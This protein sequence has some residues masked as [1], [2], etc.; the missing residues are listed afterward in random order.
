MPSFAF[1]MRRPLD[2]SL[3]SR[4]LAALRRLGH[5]YSDAEVA[6][7]AADALA[8]AERIAG[9]LRAAGIELS[10]V[11]ARS[12]AIA[13]IAYLQSLGRGRQPQPEMAATLGEGTP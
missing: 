6:N 10:E 5:P 3:T 7:A 13:L 12:E 1:M 8:E 11:E 9:S 2:T 4:R